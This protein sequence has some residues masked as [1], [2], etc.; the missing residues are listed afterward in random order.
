MNYRFFLISF[1]I[2][3]AQLNSQ[4][5]LIITSIILFASYLSLLIKKYNIKNN[6]LEIF[7]IL[8]LVSFDIPPFDNTLW[9][10]SQGGSGLIGTP[11][12]KFAYLF[13]FII[14]SIQLVKNK[15]ISIVSVSLIILLFIHTIWNYVFFN[16][17]GIF[18]FVIFILFFIEN[19]KILEKK[20]NIDLFYRVVRYSLIAIFFREL[21]LIALNI[22]NAQE[23]LS[24][25]QKPYLSFIYVYLSKCLNKKIGLLGILAVALNLLPVG[26]SDILWLILII[27]LSKS[28]VIVFT[29]PFIFYLVYGENNFLLIRLDEILRI[30]SS[31]SF[32]NNDIA[33]SIGVRISEF[34]VL[35][36]NSMDSIPSLFFG[37]FYGGLPIEDI[38]SLSG[39]VSSFDFPEDDISSGRTYYLHGFYNVFLF[40]SGLFG[41]YIYLLNAY[42]SSFHGFNYYKCLIPSIIL[43]CAYT[44]IYPS[45]DMLIVFLCISPSFNKLLIRKNNNI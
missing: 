6:I 15:S 9:E 41:L 21:Y 44:T 29:I 25:G 12:A 32:D 8:C 17:I 4:L 26:K 5:A 34:S 13:V 2:A 24:F 38:Q 23:Y 33:T 31:M 37:S 30:I 40:N 28:L 7:L 14:I 1:F 45:I 36:K 20:I 27:F 35:M 22:F 19:K 16:A 10:A 39:K 43:L 42:K 3:F 18:W 11:L